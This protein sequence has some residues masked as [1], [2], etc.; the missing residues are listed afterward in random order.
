MTENDKKDRREK[1][2]EHLGKKLVGIANL[3]SPNWFLIYLAWNGVEILFKFFKKRFV[4]GELTF[5]DMKF[6]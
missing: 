6:A 1:K 2:K 5:L 3:S 4:F